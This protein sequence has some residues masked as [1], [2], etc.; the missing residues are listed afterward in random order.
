MR[1]ILLLP[2]PLLLLLATV[3]AG[4][5]IDLVTL[6]D[7]ASVQLTIYNSED[8]TLVRET[9]QIA[10]KRGRN[11]L[12]FSW[13]NTLIDPTSVEFRALERPGEIELVDTRF[14]GAKPQHLVWTIDSQYEGQVKVEVSYF[15]SGITWS[16]DYVALTDAREE[17]LAFRGYVRVSNSSGEEYDNA[18]VRLIVG[19]INLVER[20][21]EL[22]Q[23]R[24]L[25]MPADESK[26][27]GEMKRE[28][29]KAAFARAE[30]ARDQAAGKDIV[31]EGLSEYFMFSVSGTETIRNGWSK[32]MEAVK[33]DG[34]KLATVYRLRA[35]QYGPRPVRFLLWKNDAEHG[36]G[37]S[38]LPDG[39]LRVL[40]ANAD[41]G[42]SLLGEETVSYV[43]IQAPIEVNLGPDDRVDCETVAGATRR[44]D[45]RFDNHPR[46][47]VGWTE[48]AKWQDRVKNSRDRE[49]VFELQRVEDGDVEHS[50]EMETKLFDY[51]TI[52]TRFVVA[53][54]GE[55]TYPSTVVRR[56]AASQRQQRVALR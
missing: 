41:E 55:V 39:R 48:E 2:A 47:V 5:N 37:G 22:A 16:M 9:R 49:I 46:R 12:Q 44:Y 45:F 29:A 40:R 21:A 14:P 38:P 53:P 54:R 26:L 11:Q 34:V 24:G 52:E 1:R 17:S 43:P 15:T 30:E 42:L 56:H 4:K 31:K 50:S 19:R 20:I 32:R 51:R 6:P 3:A 25:P 35:H 23:R 7:R 13:A 27:Y 18:E 28:G 10:L 36:L 8:L 33:A